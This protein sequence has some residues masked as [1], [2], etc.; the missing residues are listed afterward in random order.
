MHCDCAQAT[1][2]ANGLQF[3][4]D[5][6][7]DFDASGASDNLIAQYEV[8]SGDTL[9]A[10]AQR[11]GIS[12]QAL[13]DA[14]PQIVNPNLIYPGDLVTLPGVQTVVV[15][16]GDTL[17]E[18]AQQYGTTVDALVATNRIGNPD[19]IYPGDVLVI[20]GTASAEPRTTPVSNESPPGNPIVPFVGSPTNLPVGGRFDYNQIAGVAGNPNVTSEFVAEVE[21]M[22]ERLGTRPEYLLAVMSFETGGTFSPSERNP[23][24]TATGLIQFISTTANNLG[25]SVEEL[26]SMTP[27]EQLRFVEQYFAPFAGRLDTLEAVYT[28]VLTGHPIVDPA[29]TLTTASGIAFVRGTE[30][31][32]RNAGLDLN[33][34]GKITAGEATALVASRLNAGTPPTAS[35][36]IA[37]LGFSQPIHERGTPGRQTIQSPV[38][39]EFMITEGFMARGGPHTS[40]LAR[41]AIFSE[42]P[43]QAELVPAGVYNLGI[44]YVASNGRIQSWFSGVVTDQTY[45]ADGYGHRLVIRSD[46]TFSYQGRDYPIYAHYA[47]A[48]DFS[49]GVDD[50]VQA[51]QDI[52]TQGSTGHSTGDHVDFLTWIELDN[53][54]RV[55]ISPNLIS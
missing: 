38:I 20:P 33:R 12:L 8:K 3:Q 29:A 24:S 7:V 41:N 44:D 14:N 46:Q 54:S 25:T 49:V 10:I 16:P 13:I 11:Y 42:N 22:A 26:A 47:H 23:E 27:I 34:D 48:D 19:L 2:T 21:A 50:A 39:G 17:S 15:Q 35:G 43:T 37:D 28:S 6:G 55:Y 1:S 40:K 53:G 4:P 18:L 51:G 31:Y 5:N 9:S 52:G 32:A 30:V 45:D 36:E